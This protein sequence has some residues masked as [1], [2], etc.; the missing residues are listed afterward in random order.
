MN[1]EDKEI[2]LEVPDH[3][4]DRSI[5]AFSAPADPKKPMV[6]NVVITREKPNPGENFDEYANRQL[7]Q[8]ARTVNQFKLLNHSKTTLGGAPAV[9]IGFAWRHE[10][11]GV[12]L[13]QRQLIVQRGPRMLSIVLTAT[14]E[15]Y[16]ALE[17]EFEAILA[18]VRMR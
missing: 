13:Q 4:E 11:L 10:V 17:A 14:D 16:A 2:A 15:D 1:Y 3:W 18:T 7:V 12:S 9:D 6:P 5:I 8:N